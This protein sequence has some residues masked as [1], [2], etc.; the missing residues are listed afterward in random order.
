[1]GGVFSNHL[2]NKIIYTLWPKVGNAAW[3]KAHIAISNIVEKFYNKLSDK[4]WVGVGGNL[5]GQIWNISW[6]VI[7]ILR[8]KL[9]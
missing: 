7:L 6:R 2:S 5:N 9:K 3:L 4:I 1:M 8:N